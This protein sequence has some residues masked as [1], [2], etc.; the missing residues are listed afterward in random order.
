MVALLLKLFLGFGVLV[1]PGGLLVLSAVALYR[2]FR[3]DKPV[4]LLPTR[5][6][7]IPAGVV[8][9]EFSRACPSSICY[10]P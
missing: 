3:R 5:Q 4:S 10:R 7:R 2:R 6:A 8:S 9:P 1:M